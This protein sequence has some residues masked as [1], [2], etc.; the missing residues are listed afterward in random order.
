MMV[1]KVPI[2]FEIDGSVKNI[3]LLSERLQA[4][5]EETIGPKGLK[6]SK[7]NLENLKEI[8]VGVFKDIHSIPKMVLLER[9]RGINKTSNSNKE[10]NYFE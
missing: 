7:R 1:I 4:L 2:Y 6:V 5:L 3:E 8:E 10:K 9:M